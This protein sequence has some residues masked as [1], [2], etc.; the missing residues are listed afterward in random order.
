MNI[1]SI[2]LSILIMLLIL[3]VL[4]V[5]HEWG[6]YI[7][8][9]IFGV[10]VNEFA[11]FM[12]P[13]LFS[14]KG[15]K[16]G[17][18]FSIRCLPLGGFCAMEGEET[19]ESSDGAFCNKPR[20]QRA[21]ILL[22]GVFMNILLAIL[23][24][25]VIFAVNG[26]TTNSINSVSSYGPMALTELEP[27]DRLTEYNGYRILNDLDY[28]LATY[29][30]GQEDTEFTIKKQNGT[31]QT[32]KLVRSVDEANKTAEVQVYRL[33]QKEQT[34][35]GSY[36]TVWNENGFTADLTRADQS[37]ERYEF[38]KASENGT[39]RYTSTKTEYDSQS[40]VIRTE[41][42]F[43]SESEVKTALINFSPY[44]YGMS[45]LYVEHANLFKTIGNA[46]LYNVSLVKSVFN[47]LKWLIT[48]RLGMDAMSGPIGLTTVV[49]DLVTA[50]ASVGLRIGALFEM[51]ALIS[52]NLAAFNVL[53]IPGLDG[54]KMIFVILEFIRRGKKVPPEKEA[55]VSLIFLA[56]LILFSIFVAG[57]DILRIIRS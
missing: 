20:W 21:I 3:T 6:H 41:P 2:A 28:Q 49:N 30:E 15:K 31:K 44:R 51:A 26:Y 7:A 16:T 46:V 12:G 27:G 43:C 25:T 37:G 54:G 47:S 35:L 36:K 39:E 55:V 32:Y 11:I 19:T 17:T 9:R 8:A 34:L 1:L 23:I 22:A 5:V 52:A 4:V 57:N 14:R 24:M 42:S 38:V 18:V 53:P 45:F 48:G 50:P 33:E 40:N 10:K 29:V 13:K 56:L